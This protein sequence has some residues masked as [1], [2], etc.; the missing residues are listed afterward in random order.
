[1]GILGGMILFGAWIIFGGMSAIRSL[2]ISSQLSQMPYSGPNFNH[3]RQIEIHNILKKI[4]ETGNLRSPLDDMYG[5]HEVY[6]CAAYCSN[7]L[8]FYGLMLHK[9]ADDEGWE[10]DPGLMIRLLDE[11]QFDLWSH[12]KTI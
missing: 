2:V 7:D 4:I 9:V 11:N 5:E 12:Q 6:M 8:Q 1:M 10:S 3:E